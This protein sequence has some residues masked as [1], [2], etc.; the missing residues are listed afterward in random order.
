LSPI[1]KAF[2]PKSIYRWFEEHGVPLKVEKD[3]RVFPVSDDGHD[4]VGAFEQLFVM[5]HDRID[6]LLRTKVE[7]VSQ[8]V[9]S[10][11]SCSGRFQIVTDKS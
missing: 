7:S 3:M 5:Y 1:L 11:G 4:V 8:A 6:I 9:C 2:T 10:D